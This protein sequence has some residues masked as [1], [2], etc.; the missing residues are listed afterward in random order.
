MLQLRPTLVAADW[1]PRVRRRAAAGHRLVAHARTLGCDSFVL[2]SGTQ[3]PGAHRLYLRKRMKISC[4][5][6]ERPLLP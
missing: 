4:S 2:D 6:F 1:L 3:R 5:P